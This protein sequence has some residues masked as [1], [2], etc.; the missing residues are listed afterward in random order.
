MTDKPY[1]HGDLK[2]TLL[3]TALKLMK[4][5]GS[6]SWTLR[7]V[8]RNS[9]VTHNAPYR[10]FKDKRALLA[11]LA[12]LGFGNFNA[13]LREA[14]EKNQKVGFEKLK[15]IGTAYILF[16]RANPEF[17]RLMFSRELADK[18][19]FPEL[20]EVST[21]AFSVLLESIKECQALEEIK[22]KDTLALTMTAWSMVHGFSFLV[23]DKQLPG[24]SSGDTKMLILKVL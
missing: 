19:D 8:A 16:A 12:K 23:L 9:G 15:A 11:E 10:H 22:E 7:E 17:F 1:H 24:M 6:N 5:K 4:E 21:Q 3:N 18:S 13:A 2:Q 20:F 14:S